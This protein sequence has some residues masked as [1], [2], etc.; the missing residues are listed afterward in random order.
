MARAIEVMIDTLASM[1]RRAAAPAV[2]APAH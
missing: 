1:Q 2:S